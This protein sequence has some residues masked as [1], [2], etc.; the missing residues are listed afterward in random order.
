MRLVN[1]GFGNMVVAERVICVVSADSAPIKRMISNARDKGNL[2]DSTFGRKTRAVLFTDSNHLIT[3]A[4]V[5]E[6]IAARL[7]GKSDDKDSGEDEN[8]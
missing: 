6:T 1:I 5:A 2:I 3:S 7:V 8:E 4:V